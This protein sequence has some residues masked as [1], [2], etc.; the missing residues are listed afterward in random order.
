MR[1]KSEE[2]K[3]KVM[4]ERSLP[5]PFASQASIISEMYKMNWFN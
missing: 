1:A 4:M 2:M 5:S 3:F